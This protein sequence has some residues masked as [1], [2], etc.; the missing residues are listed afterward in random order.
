MPLHIELIEP[1]P[2]HFTLIVGD[3]FA[4]HLSRD[5]ALAVVAGALFCNTSAPPFLKT[6]AEWAW[7]DTRYNQPNQQPFQPA[8]LLAWNGRTH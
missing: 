1:E 4:D 2:G 7:W 3:K 8:A 6:Y 5:E